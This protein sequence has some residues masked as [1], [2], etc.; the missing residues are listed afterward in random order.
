ME[1]AV[2]S[3]PPPGAAGAMTF[4]SICANAGV[5]ANATAAIKRPRKLGRF[6]NTMTHSSVVE[7]Y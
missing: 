4:S 7:R 1:R 2:W 5:A 6:H 3:H